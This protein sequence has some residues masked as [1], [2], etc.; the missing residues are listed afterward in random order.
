MKPSKQERNKIAAARAAEAEKRAEKEEFDRVVR[1]EGIAKRAEEM[2][3]KR[4]KEA[5]K[6]QDNA[7][8]GIGGAVDRYVDDQ[9]SIM[10]RGGQTYFSG[11][12]QKFGKRE[13]YDSLGSKP[14]EEGYWE[15]DSLGAYNAFG[16][17]RGGHV[18]A[19]YGLNIEDYEQ[20]GIGGMISSAGTAIFGNATQRMKNFMKD[21]G[22]EEITS[23]TLGREPIQAAI[24]SVME[25]ISLGEFSKSKEKRGYDAFFHLY[26][27]INGKYVLEKNQNVN[28]RAYKPSD[29]EDLFEVSLS[30]LKGKT[31]N[32]FIKNGEKLMGEGKYWQEYSPLTNNCQRFVESNLQANDID[33]AASNEF[34]Y[35]D[36]QDL[37]DA[38]NPSV[39]DL[40]EET[41][42]VAS[43]VEKFLSWLSGGAWG[44]KRGGEIGRKF[45]AMK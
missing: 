10:A 5:A 25:L 4:K 39:Q 7:R 14:K 38:I 23:I 8:G 43:G 26:L 32:E 2:E 3:K 33:S 20:Y 16:F 19:R 45:G 18:A 6:R 42:D 21:H 17:A 1:A 40:L 37:I 44:F 34:Y 30:G 36:T 29:K 11:G 9:C 27:I 12:G 13:R 22:E 15:Q 24:N 35:Q 31:I 28:Y 41:T